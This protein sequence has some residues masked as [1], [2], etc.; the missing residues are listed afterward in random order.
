MLN[1]IV[2][3]ARDKLVSLKL[4]AQKYRNTEFLDAAMAAT[5][6]I[7]VADGT[8]SLEEKKKTIA[9]VQGHEALRIFDASEVNRKLEKALSIDNMMVF[10]AI[11]AS[12]GIKGILQHRIL[13]YGIALHRECP[14][15][16]PRLIEENKILIAGHLTGFSQEHSRCI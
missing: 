12:F 6:L 9:F 4:D 13:Y 8:I 15:R 3:K 14:A 16:V 2:G 7:T 5:A 1:S 11:F 10:V